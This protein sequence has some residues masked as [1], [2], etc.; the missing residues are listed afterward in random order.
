MTITPTT[1][2]MLFPIYL[3]L[4]LFLIILAIILIIA[5]LHRKYKK[6]KYNYYKNIQDRET[7]LE[8][9]KEQNEILRNMV[10]NKGE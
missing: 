4:F 5:L 2:Q 1:E 9:L 8:L 3:G 7:E 6:A 10:N